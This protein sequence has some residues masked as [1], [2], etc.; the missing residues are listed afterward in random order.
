MEQ[1]YNAQQ[2]NPGY[3]GVNV[4]LPPKKERKMG[5]AIA[6]LVLG[7][8]SIFGLCCCC[9]NVI[10]A[11]IAI[12]LG[13][14]VL[15]K[16]MDGTG[17]AIFG[18][19]AAVLS[20]LV[21]AG[22]FYS[23]R[24]LYPHVDTIVTDYQ[25]LVSEQDEVFAAYEKDGTLPDYLEKYTEPPFSDFFAKYDITFYD[26]MDALLE[27]H[28]AGALKNPYGNMYAG[29]GTQSSAPAVTV[30]PDAVIMLPC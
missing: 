14:V 17:M 28:K 9:T 5:L 30:D 22:I 26:V 25:K 27:Q 23:M 10:F 13:I 6:T 20:L 16:H 3:E 2:P 18:I 15:V 21:L 12:I 11:P 8:L 4:T 29:T 24:D 7:I 19:V 1:N